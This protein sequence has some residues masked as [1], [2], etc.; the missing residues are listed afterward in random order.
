ML[1]A[2]YWRERAL[3]LQRR[4]DD[5]S[6]ELAA[7]RGLKPLTPE[8]IEKHNASVAELRR[9]EAFNTLPDDYEVN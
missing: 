9:R 6:K 1:D 4:C 2:E 8:Q 3:M 7:A 5:L